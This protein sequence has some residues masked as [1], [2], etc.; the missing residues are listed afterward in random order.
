MPKARTHLQEAAELSFN[1]SENTEKTEDFAEISHLRLEV[2]SHCGCL[3]EGPGADVELVR[4]ELVGRR[5]RE[6]RQQIRI[7]QD[8]HWLEKMWKTWKKE[9]QHHAQFV[10]QD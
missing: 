8:K 6:A 10:H 1:L 5:L 4:L 2:L 9:F 7:A 3:R